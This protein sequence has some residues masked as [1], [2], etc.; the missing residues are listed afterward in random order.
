[1]HYFILRA[2]F[3]HFSVEKELIFSERLHIFFHSQNII[4][5]GTIELKKLIQKK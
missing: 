5:A 3:C 4:C 1:M 2:I